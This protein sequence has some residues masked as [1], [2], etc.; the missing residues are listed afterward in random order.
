M[1]KL[2]ELRRLLI[3]VDMVNGFV[4]EGKMADPYIQHIIE[5][6][7]LLIESFLANENGVAFIKENHNKD[8]AEFK[9]YPEHCINGTAEALLVDDLRKYEDLSL[10]YLKNCT[11]ALFAP[12]FL[13]DIDKMKSLREVIVT[14][15]C[16]DICV[17]NLVIPLKNYFDQ[18]DRD[19]KIIVPETAVETYNSPTHNRD[20]YNEMA[21]KLM[22]QAG[23]EVVKQYRLERK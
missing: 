18:I 15:C 2:D 11:C 21:F 20:E 1:N 5:E 13:N 16:T 14:G 23:I 3:V 10:A 7:V 8:C 22:K 4:K 19:V 6:N 9:R 12:Q 17:M